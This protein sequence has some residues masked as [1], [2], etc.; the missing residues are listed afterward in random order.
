[1]EKA[2]GQYLL[3]N[4]NLIILNFST[5]IAGVFGSYRPISTRLHTINNLK[6][7]YKYKYTDPLYDNVTPYYA[8]MKTN[9]R[10]CEWQISAIIATS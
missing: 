4:N 7:V 5:L 3:N 1:M 2:I 9:A 10:A 6:S 8:I